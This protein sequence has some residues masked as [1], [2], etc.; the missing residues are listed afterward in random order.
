MF[1]KS[2][3]GMLSSL[4]L[5][6]RARVRENAR[7]QGSF[8]HPHPDPLPR[9]GEREESAI[10]LLGAIRWVSTSGCNTDST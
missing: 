3:E 9:A 2:F 5:W 1:K 10:A 4:S 6:E 8:E 7:Q